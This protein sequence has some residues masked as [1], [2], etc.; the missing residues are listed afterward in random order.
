MILYSSPLACSSAAH[1]LLLE[2]AIPHE[3]IFVDIYVQPHRLIPDTRE[4]SAVNP[5]NAVPALEL[6][7][8]EVLTEV[9][10]ILQYLSDLCPGN[11]FWRAPGTMAR[12]REMEWLSFVGSDVHKTIGPLFNPALSDVAK[13]VHRANLRRRMIYIEECLSRTPYLTGEAFSLAD[14]YLF[15][16]IG[17]DNY[18]KMDISEYPSVERFHQRV[19]S[20]PSFRRLLELMQ[21]ALE[22]IKLP[23]FPR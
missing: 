7:S 12:Y 23:T 11:A 13:G 8:G 15:V 18:W 9:A 6:D 4:F 3:V 14:A 16:M 19:A 1:M 20:R 5:K 10:V 22:Q 2:L 21:P 17:W